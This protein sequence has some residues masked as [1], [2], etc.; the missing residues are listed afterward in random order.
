M[1]S[2]TR[3]TNRQSRL[4]TLQRWHRGNYRLHQLKGCE[5]QIQ[6]RRGQI[7]RRK[8]RNHNRN[9]KAGPAKFAAA[10]P[11]IVKIPVPTM[12]PIPKI[13]KSHNRKWRFRPGVPCPSPFF[14]IDSCLFSHLMS[15]FYHTW[16]EKGDTFFPLS[17]YLSL[18][19]LF[20][21]K[22]ES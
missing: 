16:T 18:S 11:V 2:I 14:E 7:S 5:M 1:N 15:L 3:S 12:A 20:F 8:S 10:V 21:S 4:E 6:Q 17:Y 13:I 19:V 22:H 9:D